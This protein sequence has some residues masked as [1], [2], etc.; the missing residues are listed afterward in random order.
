M[1][2]VLLLYCNIVFIWYNC[3][4][5]VVLLYCVHCRSVSKQGVLQVNGQQVTDSDHNEV[6]KLIQVDCLSVCLLSWYISIRIRRV[7][8]L[9]LLIV[10]LCMFL[11]IYLSIYLCVY[12]CISDTVTPL[13]SH[14]QFTSIIL[15]CLFNCFLVRSIYL[16][17]YLSIHLSIHL[18]IYLSI[19]LFICRA[20][21]TWP[22]PWSTPPGSWTPPGTTNQSIMFMFS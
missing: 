5:T 3:H 21:A 8:Y 2:Y 14:T 15:V 12:L 1:Q 9:Y 20:A 13:S 7:V 6:V 11:S 18:S 4:D 22:W 19:S 10:Y 17:I 16:S